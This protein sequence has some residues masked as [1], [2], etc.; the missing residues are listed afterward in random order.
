MLQEVEPIDPATLDMQDGLP[1]VDEALWDR[2]GAQI[3][4][5]SVGKIQDVSDRGAT[6]ERPI[7]D[8]T[9]FPVPIQPKLVV[10]LEDGVLLTEGYKLGL[11]KEEMD[12]P[13]METTPVELEAQLFGDSG[14]RL[15]SEG[16]QLSNVRKKGIGRVKWHADYQPPVRRRA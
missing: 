11:H 6:F 15:V 5:R 14:D 3:R 10:K 16:Q 8:T 1:P 2:Q 9:V 12:I 13:L 7:G 4:G